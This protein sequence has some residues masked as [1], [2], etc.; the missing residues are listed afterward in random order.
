MV[1]RPRPGQVFAPEGFIEEFRRVAEI[2]VVRDRAAPLRSAAA[3]EMHVE[4][5]KRDDG[6]AGCMHRI[7]PALVLNSLGRRS[8]SDRL[9]PKA[10][11]VDHE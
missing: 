11:G 5:R 8:R 4:T 9:R 6:D 7:R 3:T 1:T 2:H 10:A